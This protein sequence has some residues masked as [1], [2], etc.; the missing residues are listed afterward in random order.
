MWR[1]E[2]RHAAETAYLELWLAAADQVRASVAAEQIRA[3]ATDRTA[4]TA[5]EA[6]RQGLQEELGAAER[7][8]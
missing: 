8:P 5:R 6:L 3:M 4:A 2:R 1:L 7:N